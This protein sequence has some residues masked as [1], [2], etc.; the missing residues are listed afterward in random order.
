MHMVCLKVKHP[1]FIIF[2]IHSLLLKQRMLTLLFTCLIT[3]TASKY[4]YLLC[5]EVDV[6][7]L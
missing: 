4:W 1:I 7:F 6:K 3:D 5:V 2:I